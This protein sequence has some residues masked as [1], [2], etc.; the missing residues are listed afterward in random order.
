VQKERFWDALQFP[1][2]PSFEYS[3]YRKS[4]SISAGLGEIL[5]PL[6]ISPS[7]IKPIG[8]HLCKPNCS[9]DLLV[10]A[11]MGMGDPIDLCSMVF[12]LGAKT[13]EFCVSERALDTCSNVQEAPFPICP[14]ATRNYVTA[15]L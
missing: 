8:Q 14:S 6:F 10:P 1:I 7:F 2:F 15:F 9:I 12:Y 5:S 13:I 4:F 11:V 3:Y